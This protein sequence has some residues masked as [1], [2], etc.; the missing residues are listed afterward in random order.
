MFNIQ[1]IDNTSLLLE[2][3]FRQIRLRLKNQWYLHY[4]CRRYVFKIFAILLGSVKSLSR[5]R[6]Y[7]LKI[8]FPFKQWAFEFQPRYY[9]FD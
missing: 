2:P 5:A 3:P 7:S 4:A 6:S 8:G 1:E 9:S